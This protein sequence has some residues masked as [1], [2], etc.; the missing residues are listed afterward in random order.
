MNNSRSRTA[1]SLIA[2]QIA[3]PLPVISRFLS[4]KNWRRNPQATE[5][6]DLDGLGCIK[7]TFETFVLSYHSAFFFDR[8]FSSANNLRVI[9]KLPSF[10]IE[11][12]MCVKISRNQ[13]SVILRTFPNF[14]SRNRVAFH[15]FP[16][17]IWISRL[18]YQREC[19]IHSRISYTEIHNFAA[20]SLFPF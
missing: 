17:I 2:N 13:S 5:E 7:R 20:K 6:V 19:E 9:F 1:G 4:A 3:F 11:A 18:G 10:D 14:A 12:R 16:W 15:E 8:S